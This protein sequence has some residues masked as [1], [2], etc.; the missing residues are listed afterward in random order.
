MYLHRTEYTIH[1]LIFSC[2][3]YINCLNLFNKSAEQ[4]FFQ[5]TGEDKKLAKSEESKTMVCS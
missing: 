1:A 2:L 3:L 5:A 4:T